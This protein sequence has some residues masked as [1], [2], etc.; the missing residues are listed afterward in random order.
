MIVTLTANPSIDRTVALAGPL[1]RGSVQRADVGDL[2]GRRQGRQHLA[3]RRQRRRPD[4][5]RAPAAKDDPFVAR[6]ARRRHRLPAGAPRRRRAGQ[7][8]DHRARRHHHQAQ[9][10]RRRPSTP[11]PPRAD[12]SE[13]PRAAR[14]DADWVVLAGSLP[15]GAPAEWYAE[16]VAA[17]RDA[18]AQVAVDTSD[19]AAPRARR[20]AAGL[21]RPT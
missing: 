11:A 13:P 6:A 21:A 1:A 2:A 17:L 18:G 19:A 7:P 14:V 3:R 4:H 9:L 16:L 20:R 8:H 10:P 5:R 12:G 15:P